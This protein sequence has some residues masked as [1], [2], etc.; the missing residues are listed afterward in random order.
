MKSLIV[1]LSLLSCFQ[2]AAQPVN[3]TDAK[4]KKQGK[5]EK[6]YPKS[7]VYEYKGQFKDGKPVGTF[8]YY[9]EN[10]RTKAVIVHDEK[11][12]RSAATMYHETGQ[13]FGRGIYRNQLKDSIWDYYGPSGR[14]SLKETYSKNLLHGQ[15]T[16]YYVSEDANDN[17]MK[18]AKVSNYVKGVLEG[19][20]IEYF[21]SGT[22]KSK[23]QFIAGKRN[24]AYTINHPN[25]KPMILERY[26]NGARHGWCAT[27][28]GNG[29][30]LGKKYFYYGRELEGKELEL[31]MKQM[32]ELGINPNG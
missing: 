26:K 11:T 21:E 1:I 4:G 31:K 3:Q 7:K 6:L 5:W 10:G 8:T 29:K 9:Y 14:Q 17:S 2:L 15:T 22:I 18:V 27:Y 25:G 24:G 32:K 28:D 19:E 30:E 16:V 13:L 12:G 23:G 20:E